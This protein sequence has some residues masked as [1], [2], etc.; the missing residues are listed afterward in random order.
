MLSFQ[1]EKR[2][3]YK[4]KT[5]TMRRL[6]FQNSLQ[7]KVYWSEERCGARIFLK[8]KKP[9]LKSSKILLRASN[10]VI[11]S[12]EMSDAV[13]GQIRTIEVKLAVNNTVEEVLKREEADILETLNTVLEGYKGR[14]KVA[15]NTKAVSLKAGYTGLCSIDSLLNL[16][17]SSELINSEHPLCDHK[18]RCALCIV[19][20]AL[21]KIETSTDKKKFVKLQ[22]IEKNLQ[23]FLGKFFCRSC[24][25]P[26]EQSASHT[27][28]IIKPA[29]ISLKSTL[30]TFL[31]Q[32]NV[33]QSFNIDIVCQACSLNINPFSEGYF[34]V[35]EM[36]R[37]LGK[38]SERMSEMFKYIKKNHA[39]K[40]MK[41]SE[42]KITLKNLPTN[43][44]VMMPTKTLQEFEKTYVLGK[45]EYFYAGHIN[46]N[47]GLLTNHFTTTAM[48]K[49]GNFVE[50][51]GKEC[52]VIQEPNI[53]KA[54][55][56]LYIKKMP[57]MASEDFVYR[58]TAIKYFS[59]DPEERKRKHEKEYDAEKAKAAYD[60]EKTKAAYD[61]EK[62]K[63]AYNPEKAK[64]DYNPEERKRKHEKEYDPEKAKQKRAQALL[65]SEHKSGFQSICVSC[66][67]WGNNT[68]R[69]NREEDFGVRFP[70][71]TKD[72]FFLL[73]DMKYEGKWRLCDT[74]YRAFKEGR[75]P[76]LNMRKTEDFK[77]IGEVPT[78]LPKLNNLEAYLIKIRIPFL[79][80]ANMPRS[81]NMKCYGP[82]VCVSAD[83]NHSIQKIEN[84]LELQHE[85]LIPVNFKR[86]LSFTGSYIS[87]V[88]DPAKVF[89]WLDYLKKENHL[90]KD[91]NYDKA[92]LS[93]EIK[94][95]EKLLVRQAALF[96]DLNKGD[97]EDEKEDDD[98][99][100]YN[101]SSD[102]ECGDEEQEV[103]KKVKDFTK[104]DNVQPQDTLL[105][106][107]RQSNLEENSVTNCIA[108]AI[109]EKEKNFIDNEEEIF[110]SDDECESE[111]EIV[112][113]KSNRG[114]KEKGSPPFSHNFDKIS[115][116]EKST[117]EK[118]SNLEKAK[119]IFSNKP[120]KNKKETVL[121]VAPGEGGKINNEAVFGEAQCFP[122][123]FP[124]GTGTYLSYVE[125]GLQ[126]GI[127]AYNKLRL[128]GGLN[129]TEKNGV[130]LDDELK[131]KIL[132]FEKE[133][134]IN[135]ERFR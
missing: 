63:A 112:E 43:L 6:W 67:R 86:K 51:S 133:A 75:V 11:L 72:D 101:D 109:I 65:K 37:D 114:Y 107:I 23:I 12:Q 13:K 4:S 2:I 92:T 81:P 50:Y 62:A 46:Y 7:R 35:Q 126:I 113:E 49:E 59:Y 48:T 80:L 69:I 29:E 83:I 45:H 21:V 135:Y 28:P 40:S 125:A 42:S 27:C 38:L 110:Y 33:T 53:S 102:D 44:L 116:N 31:T 54:V 104:E 119:K 85:T 71:A 58:N 52:K 123:L 93:N 103:R 90:Y 131:E 18:L 56:M 17:K 94:N 132:S 105:I 124:R 77:K 129:L 64:A 118:T 8:I 22:E 1:E 82:M 3:E 57:V 70:A 130:Y 68:N 96:D 84:R 91:L 9:T 128:T 55:L 78:H 19:R 74:C 121:N 61:P 89:V 34:K 87:K 97:L 15:K 10:E 120:K 20:S 122:E 95:Y 30:E 76:L 79:R 73:P 134:N 99:D 115:K 26:I 98:Y 36:S 41:C 14:G 32:P 117:P 111:E 100:D 24:Y 47:T 106:D 66:T 88:I 25:G 5:V 108:D 60:P 127:S 39:E 16:F